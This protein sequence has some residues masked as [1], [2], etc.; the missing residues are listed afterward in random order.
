[1]KAA[2]SPLRGLFTLLDLPCTAYAVGC[3]LTP[4]RGCYFMSELGF[5]VLLVVPVEELMGDLPLAVA[6]QQ[7]EDVRGSRVGAGQ[8][9]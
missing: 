3:I 9:A 1:V 4:L 7:S 2:L 6:L 8:L 5:A